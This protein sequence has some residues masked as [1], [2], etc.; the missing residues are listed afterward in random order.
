MACVSG[1]A[2][3]LQE[4]RHKATNGSRFTEKSSFGQGVHSFIPVDTN[5]ARDPVQGD[6]VSS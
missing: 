6:G 3:T 5:V 2:G 4:A 1:G